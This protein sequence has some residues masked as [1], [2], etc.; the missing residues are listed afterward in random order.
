[1]LEKD[2]PLKKH[3]DKEKQKVPTNSNIIKEIFFK[4]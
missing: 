3:G 4:E 1:M 2:I